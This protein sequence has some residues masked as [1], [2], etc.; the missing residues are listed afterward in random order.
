MGNTI[1]TSPQRRGDCL[2]NMI[3]VDLLTFTGAT[4]VA[5]S[6]LFIMKRL[7]DH[8]RPG[9]T[10]GLLCMEVCRFIER[11]RVYKGLPRYGQEGAWPGHR[12]G[13]TYG[14]WRGIETGSRRL[15][16][17]SVVNLSTTQFRHRASH[18]HGS[19][20]MYCLYRSTRR[21]SST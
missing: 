4:P 2:A 1:M 17:I 6:L 9:K 10:L 13:D 5:I 20:I 21:R 16:V 15:S 11:G 3:A 7:S 8:I 18:S 19:R 12:D 14:G